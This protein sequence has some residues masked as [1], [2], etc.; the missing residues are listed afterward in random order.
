MAAALVSLVHLVDHNIFP[1]L[2]Y[3]DPLTMRLIRIL[4]LYEDEIEL[5]NDLT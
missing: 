3:V 4:F 5:V 1:I 2:N